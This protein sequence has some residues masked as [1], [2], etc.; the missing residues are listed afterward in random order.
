MGRFDPSCPIV[1]QVTD[2]RIP[3]EIC[4]SEAEGRR[5]LRS[6]RRFIRSFCDRR[7][8][9]R[10]PGKQTPRIAR[11]SRD[12]STLLDSGLAPSMAFEPTLKRFKPNPARRDPGA[13]RHAIPLQCRGFADAGT[14]R[15]A[16]AIWRRL[17]KRRSAPALSGW[18]SSKALNFGGWPEITESADE[19]E[20][21]LSVFIC[22]S[23]SVVFRAVL[24]ASVSHCSIRFGSITPRSSPAAPSCS[25]PAPAP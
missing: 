3:K 1:D 6:P 9:M 12:G 13:V 17:W 8:A 14:I 16:E 24:C 23:I 18:W 5:L 7:W 2:L 10:N 21:M 4:H 25:P 20:D 15:P 22:G 11:G 19:P